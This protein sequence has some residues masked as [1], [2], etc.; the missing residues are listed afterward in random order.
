[1]YSARRPFHPKRLWDLMSKPFCVLQNTVDEDE[2]EDDEEDADSTNEDED[3]ADTEETE[4]EETKDEILARLQQ[5]KAEL[6]LPARAAAKRASPVFKGLLRSKGFCWLATRPQLHGEWSQAGVSEGLTRC[7]A[8]QRH[9][10][11]PSIRRSCSRSKV[12][13][14]GCAASTKANGRPTTRTSSR[15]SRRTLRATGVTAGRNV[16]IA[17]THTDWI[18]SALSGLVVFIGQ[19]LDQELLTKTLD[20]VLLDDKE[21]TQW[22]K[23]SNP[24]NISRL[25]VD[26]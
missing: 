18:Y 13:D 19:E 7:S 10:T 17:R 20:A 5:E 11:D 23:V 16:S 9:V 22:Q 3:G 24:R 1:M 21:W 25:T 4:V 6:D 2:D 26:H 8:N 14:R 12:A 15:R